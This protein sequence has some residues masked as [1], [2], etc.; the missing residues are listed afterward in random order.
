MAHRSRSP[1]R[2]SVIGRRKLGYPVCVS[3]EAN[4]RL[5]QTSW[6]SVYPAM[7]N[8]ENILVVSR[9]LLYPRLQPEN[10][11]LANAWVVT[12]SCLVGLLERKTN[13]TK[14]ASVTR[15]R[16]RQAD[17]YQRR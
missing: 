5:S 1:T 12:P 16:S 10:P 9:I 3:A 13:V 11:N 17:V 6:S 14:P 7:R 2:I 15:S 8:E 4:V